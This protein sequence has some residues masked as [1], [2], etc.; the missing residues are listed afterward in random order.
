MSAPLLATKPCGRCGE[1]KPLSEFYRDAK[2]KDGH[3]Y[4]CK[5]CC[6]L[7][8]RQS[9]ERMR[10]AMGEAA[11]R[12]YVRE[13]QRRSRERTGNSRG[14]AYNRA[15]YAALSAL[16]DAHRNQYDALLQRELYERGLL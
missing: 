8:V 5:P 11:W 3:A 7:Q 4:A 1:T 2:R 13:N 14:K 9:Q 6:R 12:D 15:Q 10:K 16:R